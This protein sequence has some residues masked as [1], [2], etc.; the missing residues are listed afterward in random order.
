M[1]M[2]R[3]SLCCLQEAIANTAAASVLVVALQA[4]QSTPR[5]S[6]STEPK[7]LRDLTELVGDPECLLGPIQVHDDYVHPGKGWVLDP[8]ALRQGQEFSVLSATA[9]DG[10]IWIR[11]ATSHYAA[12]LVLQESE[13]ELVAF[14]RVFYAYDTARGCLDDVDGW[15]MV[16][17]DLLTEAEPVGLEFKLTGIR[18]D[19]MPRECMHGRLTLHP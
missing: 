3:P 18:G 16:Y 6:A 11:A 4:C 12:T 17:S 10:A 9:D 5:E 14:G 19:G 2:R 15:V 7:A 8:I 1:G 13:G